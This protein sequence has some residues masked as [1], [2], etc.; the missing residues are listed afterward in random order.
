MTNPTELLDS[1]SNELYNKG[2]WRWTGKDGSKARVLTAMQKM[3]KA[4]MSDRDVQETIIELESAFYVEH[5]KHVK[6]KTG[7]SVREFM[8]Q[9]LKDLGPLPTTL[10]QEQNKDH[11]HAC[12]SSCPS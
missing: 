6:A 12:A 7:L 3:L 10:P 9:K 11:E 8:E 5:E 2:E 1:F 4:G